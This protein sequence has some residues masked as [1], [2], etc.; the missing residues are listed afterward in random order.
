MPGNIKIEIRIIFHWVIDF[1][2]GATSMNKKLSLLMFLLTVNCLLFT[3][4]VYA[5]G[6]AP[7]TPSQEV[8]IIERIATQTGVF[9]P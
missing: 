4:F 2:K 8:E 3:S 1:E 7:P 6:T 9:K 5:M